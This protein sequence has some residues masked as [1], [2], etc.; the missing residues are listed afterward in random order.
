MRFY[1]LI[2]KIVYINLDNRT[3]RNSQIISEFKRLEIPENKILRVSAIPN[4]IC[5]HLGCS[6]SHIKV[7]E[8]AIENDWKNYLVLEDDFKFIDDIELVDKIFIYF[9]NNFD[10]KYWDV[11]NLSRGYYKNIKDIGIP[12]IQK[13]YDVSTT[14]GFLVNN[15]IYNELLNNF[16]EGLSIFKQDITQEEKYAIDRYWNK[17]LFNKNWFITNPSLGYQ[18]D[19]YSDI[20]NISVS[21]FQYDDSLNIIDL[22]KNQ[23]IQSQNIITIVSGYYNITSPK[24]SKSKYLEWLD[25]FLQMPFYLVF[26]MD[27]KK[28]K[29]VYDLIKIKRKHYTFKTYIYHLSMEEFNTYK[30]L[31]YWKYCKSIDI[32]KEYHSEELY[33]I[34]NEKIFLVERATKINP[35]RSEWFFWV[36]AG[37]IRDNLMIEKIIEFPNI[38]IIEKYLKKDKILFSLV[39]DFKKEDFIL[40]NNNIPIILKNRNEMT[41]CKVLSL[42]QGGFF[43]CHLKMI[44]T[45]VKMFINEIEWFKYT[46]T[47]GGKEQNLFISMFIKYTNDFIL[48]LSYI[49][50]VNSVDV[51]KK[52]DVWFRFYFCFSSNHLNKMNVIEKDELLKSLEFTD[53]NKKITDITG[54]KENTEFEDVNKKI[55]SH[56]EINENTELIDNKVITQIYKNMSRKFKR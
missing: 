5:G 1:D 19:S 49:D 34:W 3:Y 52:V 8:L 16:V 13:V 29:D 45:F 27:V 44:Q 11:L 14:S 23:E 20:S 53:I 22:L 6:A 43:G 18:R 41:S 33:M 40:N 36:D 10:D 51:L 37:S 48:F 7:I 39:N 55:L 56:K 2:D 42:I 24:H 9:F 17:L 50:I 38:Q 28:D 35:F 4:K 46:N 21:Y 12:Y 47:F 30:Y 31:D 32:E 26:F 54:E 25:N 15:K